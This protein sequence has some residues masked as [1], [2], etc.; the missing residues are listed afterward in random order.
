MRFFV[1]VASLNYRRLY[2]Q[3]LQ[4]IDGLAPWQLATLATAVTERAWPNFA[5]FCQITEYGQPDELRHAL[6]MVWDYCSGLQSSKN[7]ERYLELLD[8]NTPSTDDFEMFG[9][10]PALDFTTGLH[11][12]L[13]CA[14]KSSP[15]ETASALTVSL[16]TI[17]KLIEYTEADTLE[18]IE[19]NDYI[20]QH[21]L[22]QA[23]EAFIDYLIETML[24]KPKQAKEFVREMKA[25]A[26]NNGV[27]QLGISVD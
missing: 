16:T 27:S 4:R 20:E 14:M 7:F 5:L 11:C 22:Y 19:L 18:G 24:Q 6:N 2:I 13:L 1:L 8:E 21:E 12:T 15:E 23:Q 17:G 3:T 26:M 9:V 25:V 10:E